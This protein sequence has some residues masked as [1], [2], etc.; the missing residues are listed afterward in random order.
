M[1]GRIPVD[2]AGRRFGAT[3]AR[4]YS[5]RD[6]PSGRRGGWDC[7]CDCA[8]THWVPAKAL[9]SGR[10]SRCADCANRRKTSHSATTRGRKRW[11]EYRIWTSLKQRCLNP[12]NAKFADYGGR[13]IG[14][15]DRWIASFSNFI[16]DMGRRPSPELTLDRKDNDGPYAP[17]NC[18]WATRSVQSRNQRKRGAP[19]LADVMLG[20]LSCLA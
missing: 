19:D 16:A 8:R 18:R 3:I 9:L 4:D 14:V 15:C 13:G 6:A 2:L 7:A 12:R 1:A 10:V 5:F 20:A 11:P 17:E